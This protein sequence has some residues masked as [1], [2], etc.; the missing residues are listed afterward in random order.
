[1][2]LL[3]MQFPPPY[4]L[5]LLHRSIVPTS[6]SQPMQ[7]TMFHTHTQLRETFLPHLIKETLADCPNTNYTRARRYSEDQ[8]NRGI[9]KERDLNHK[10]E[11]QFSET[12]Y[13][14]T[15]KMFSLLLSSN[16]NFFVWS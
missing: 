3:A 5:I 16:R 2:R 15:A 14:N 13:L 4:R 12:F 10:T 9:R 11:C 6:C 1:M 8:G 7:E